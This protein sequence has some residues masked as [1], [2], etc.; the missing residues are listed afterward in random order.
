MI[1]ARAHTRILRRIDEVRIDVGLDENG[2]TRVDLVG[3]AIDRKRDL[4]SNARLVRRFV[5]ALDEK[6]AADPRQILDATRQP[7]FTA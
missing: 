5:E 6:L 1:L 2:Q 3:Q 7:Q 4:G